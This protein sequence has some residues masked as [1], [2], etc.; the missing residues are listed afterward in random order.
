[1]PDISPR[2]VAAG[3]LQ[4]RIT[5]GVLFLMLALG[6][7][8]PNAFDYGL[9]VLAL[10]AVGWLAGAGLKQQHRLAPLERFFL[11]AVVVF[12]AAWSAAWAAPGFS[13]GG[14]SMALRLPNLF[15]PVP[16]YFY[17]ARAGGLESAW[18]TGWRPGPLAPERMRC[19]STLAGKPGSMAGA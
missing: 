18:G 8:V 10:L 11:L 5:G 16:S 19:G 2:P 1:M 13:D 3:T 14:R 17:L 9:A 4:S 7:Y 6:L 12:M 15:L